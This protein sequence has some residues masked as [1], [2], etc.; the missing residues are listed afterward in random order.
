M[1]FQLKIADGDPNNSSVP[2]WASTS[3]QYTSSASDGGI[4][5]DQSIDLSV[6]VSNTGPDT[7]FDVQSDLYFCYP[8]TQPAWS[9]FN[10]AAG[11]PVSP[12]MANG[13]TVVSP[14]FS[15][16]PSW[17]DIGLASGDDLHGCFVAVAFGAAAAGGA[18]EGRVFPPFVAPNDPPTA[19]QIA[20]R[21]VNVKKTEPAPPAPPPG[22]ARGM[23]SGM[24]FGMGNP[25]G[26][27]ARVDIRVRRATRQETERLMRSMLSRARL[28]AWDHAPELGFGLVPVETDVVLPVRELV[29]APRP[30]VRPGGVR[31]PRVFAPLP[32]A[33]RAGV[34]QPVR[35]TV[36]RGPIQTEVLR[37]G[38]VSL[39]QLDLANPL[40]ASRTVQF[41]GV[42]T[43]TTGVL[44]QQFG[45]AARTQRPVLFAV[46]RLPRTARLRFGA[47]RALALFFIEQLV[48]ARVVGGLAYLTYTD[49]G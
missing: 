36:V 15:W 16:T 23:G 12:Q 33:S 20:Q 30:V 46:Q 11:Q 42:R 24:G 39:P 7:A 9:A 13:A 5:W 35:T 41:A 48:G 6:Q 49:L 4:H 26:A 44:R 37:T 22:G 14:S 45:V 38:R 8:S 47:R 31:D 28:G 32:V 17:Q 34:A 10:V 2:W 29:A 18:A 19:L 40:W 27:D 25:S 1:T 3:I 43:W 21:N